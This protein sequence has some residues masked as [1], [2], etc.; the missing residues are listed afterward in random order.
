MKDATLAS[1][2]YTRTRS[3]QPRD[4]D[5]RRLA[6]VVLPW[7]DVIRCPERQDPTLTYAGHKCTSLIRG[8]IGLDVRRVC[9]SAFASECGVQGG[10]VNVQSCVTADHNFPLPPNRAYIKVSTMC[11]CRLNLAWRTIGYYLER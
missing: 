1:M 9:A 4:H 3:A 6:C 8:T 11:G 5:V 7:S 10:E 2:I